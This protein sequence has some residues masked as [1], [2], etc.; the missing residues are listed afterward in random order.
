[1]VAQKN[2][3]IHVIHATNFYLAPAKHQT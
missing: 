2:Q 3:T 1:L